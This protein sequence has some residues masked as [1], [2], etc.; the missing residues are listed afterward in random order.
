MGTARRSMAQDFR[1]WE[2]E[3][4]DVEALTMFVHSCWSRIDAVWCAW[5][6]VRGELKSGEANLRLNNATWQHLAWHLGS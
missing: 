5:V 1:S 2:P 4:V 3:V 6:R